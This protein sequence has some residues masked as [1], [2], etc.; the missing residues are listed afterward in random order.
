M[1]PAA[2]GRYTVRSGDTLSAIARAHGFRDWRV[3]YA[4]NRD[5]VYDADLIFPGQVLRI[6]NAA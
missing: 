5:K 3:L 4:A 6:P 1:P 2:S